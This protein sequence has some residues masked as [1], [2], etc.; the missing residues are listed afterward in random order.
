MLKGAC[1]YSMKVELIKEIIWTECIMFY[2]QTKS[3][4][5]LISPN[6]L[7][8]YLILAD[9]EHNTWL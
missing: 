3:L 9:F 5:K 4:S 1:G 6:N 8:L 2:E 7:T